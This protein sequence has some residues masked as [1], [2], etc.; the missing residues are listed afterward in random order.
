MNKPI[1]LHIQLEQCFTTGLKKSS[2]KSFEMGL[3]DRFRP[4]RQVAADNSN[5]MSVTPEQDATRLIE[6]GRVHQNGG[7]LED[8]MQCYLAAARRAPNPARAYL[9]IGNAL[10][11]KGDL[12]GAVDAFRVA[13]KH[14]PDYAG[15][16]FNIGNAVL[17]DKQFE[18][19]ADNFRRAI[20]IQP[21]YAKAH[22]SLG[23][24]LTYLGQLDE[25]ISS[26]RNA[27]RIDP[28]LYEAHVNL[29]HVLI[30][31][32][33]KA[34]ILAG[35]GQQKEAVEI[36]RQVL[37]VKPDLPEAHYN[38]GIS[39]LAL[40]EQQDAINSFHQALNLNPE[41]A[42]A[43]CNLGVGLSGLGQNIDAIASYRRALELAP[44]F[45]EA[46]NNLGLVLKEVGQ[47]DNAISSYRLALKIN[48]DYAGAHNNLGHVLKEVGQY[49][50][51][52]SSYRLA[53]KINPDLAEAH[54]NLGNELNDLCQLASAVQ[55][56]HN[57][58][59]LKPE[60]TEAHSNLLLALNYTDKQTHEYCLDQARQFGR[61][62]SRKVTARF[63]SWSY[64]T[65]PTRLRVGLVSGDLRNH[66]VG[67]FLE[68]LL[69]H[70]DPARIELIAYPTNHR[71]DELT[72]RISSRFSSWAPLYGKSD[73]AAARMIHADGLHI[74][75]DLSGHTAHNRLPLFA[76]KSAPIQVSWLG[77]FATTGVAEMDYLLADE[78]GVPESHRSQ[79]T[80]S[81]WYL[82]DT[83]LCFSTPEF[84]VP[85]TPL[86]AMSN[87]MI[88]F[89]Y[90]QKLAKLTDDVL[91]TWGR[92]FTALPNAR[93]RMQCLQLHES[94]QNDLLQKRMLQHGINPAQV[95]MHGPTHRK[96]YLEA[97]AGIDMILD[98]F[99]FTGGTTTCEA[100]WMG[101]PTLTLAGNSLLARQ[102]ASL[103]LSAGLGDWVTTNKEEYISR[104]IALAGDKS[105]LAKLRATLRQQ[106]LTSPL[107]D[108]PRFARNLENA[109][110]GMWQHYQDENG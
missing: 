40:G 100:L 15:A 53:L 14:K 29:D 50:N 27:L 82:P 5:G 26:F 10:V 98:T 76:W 105:H 8:A 34:N 33:N 62:A 37:K 93:L 21:D 35:S 23:I 94:S 11:L 54:N 46:H 106:V 108:A 2:R 41:F 63:S 51:A 102:G 110:W 24:A 44:N 90:F 104:A 107:F 92:I 109:L 101:V 99:P 25:A 56:Y 79:F 38:L 30:E 20:A 74:L 66:P 77:Y 75:M 72:A 87:G 9:N 91:E 1:L 95:S 17:N 39:L 60:Y 49:D 96:A 84:D 57:A 18:S 81:I 80:E 97:H 61:V 86:P 6:E 36:Y 43:H 55:H 70:L 13:L 47:Y 58:L 42:E 59:K 83:R 32:Y 31:L 12:T 45:V 19:A 7:R 73:E 68:D 65:Q 3:F 85:V 67:Y 16:Y 64:A 88:T 48:P 78:T 71:E 103:L 69:T 52:I 28:N 22:C 4:S 89:G